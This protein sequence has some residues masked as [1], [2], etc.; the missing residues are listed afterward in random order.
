MIRA[1]CIGVFSDQLPVNLPPPLLDFA[2]AHYAGDDGR[3][4]AFWS[5]QTKAVTTVTLGPRRAAV[6]LH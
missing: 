1:C 6:L 4:P 2:A 3:E 5:L